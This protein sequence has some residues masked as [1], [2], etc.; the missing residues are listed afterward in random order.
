[1]VLHYQYKNQKLKK[2]TRRR[3]QEGNSIGKMGQKVLQVG[4]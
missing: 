2:N 3:E 1:M 4:N